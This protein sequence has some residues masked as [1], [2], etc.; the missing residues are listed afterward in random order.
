M[1]TAY[2]QWQV[3]QAPPQ[4]GGPPRRSGAPGGIMRH[5]FVARL[6]CRGVTAPVAH[7]QE[8]AGTTTP[9]RTSAGRKVAGA[10]VLQII[11]AFLFLIE[12]ERPDDHVVDFV[13]LDRKVGSVWALIQPLHELQCI[14][15]RVF[16]GEGADDVLEPFGIK[17]QKP[18][19]RLCASL[20]SVGPPG[21]EHRLAHPLLSL[22]RYRY[23][24]PRVV[25]APAH[26]E[27]H[28]RTDWHLQV[29]EEHVA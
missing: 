2:A 22:Q 21:P 17:H 7:V 26:H 24:V 27:E 5:P 25:E 16:S 4:G 13:L 6:S 28:P 11:L 29:R 8:A 3:Q 14:E 20:A 9:E 12:G 18:S 10:D 1:Q 19:L 15:H 23:L